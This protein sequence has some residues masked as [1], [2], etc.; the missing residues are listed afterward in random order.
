MRK[1]VKKNSKAVSRVAVRPEYHNDSKPARRRPSATTMAV[2]KTRGGGP[3]RTR[4]TPKRTA[5]EKKARGKPAIG[6][7]MKAERA[8]AVQKKRAVAGSSKGRPVK[9]AAARQGKA[10]RK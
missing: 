6:R 10:K 4:L 8:V 5:D 2:A 9:R 7:A 1:P 3:D